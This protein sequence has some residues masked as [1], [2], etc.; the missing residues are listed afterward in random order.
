MTVREIALKAL[1]ELEDDYGVQ[2]DDL[3]SVVSGYAV[4][5]AGLVWNP[6][7][8]VLKDKLDAAES[9]A[10]LGAILD[11][12]NA[13]GEEELAKHNLAKKCADAIGALI[14]NVLVGAIVKR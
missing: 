8:K 12:V 3:A 5:L 14:R 2:A 4:R 9:P 11:D 6:D 10:E 7:N 13:A 1:K